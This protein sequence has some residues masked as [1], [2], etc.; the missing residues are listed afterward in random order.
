MMKKLVFSALIFCLIFSGCTRTVYEPVV[1][2]HTLINTVTQTLTDS[3]VL[4]ALFECD[5]LGNVQL[6]ELY[7]T[8]GKMAE[9]QTQLKGGELK[10]V[11]RW[12]TK[13][14]DRVR[15]VRDTTT[16]VQIQEVTKVVKHVP[17]FFWWCFGIALFAVGF[18]GWKLFRWFL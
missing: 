3:T 6:K 9:M 10:V 17:R 2:S 14:I 18:G 4:R 7:D 8:K 13:Y 11:T 12:Q 16:V 15:E 5:S 1:K